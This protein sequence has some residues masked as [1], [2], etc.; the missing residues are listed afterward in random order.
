[1]F[2]ENNT[3]KIHQLT[4]FEI[5]ARLIFRSRLFYDDMSYVPWVIYVHD[6]HKRAKLASV[7]TVAC[8]L[9]THDL[10]IIS[11]IILFSFHRKCK[12]ESKISARYICERKP[13]TLIRAR[14][15][16]GKIPLKQF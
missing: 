8:T 10:G 7:S 3:G 13:F 6:W 9:F 2:D 4:T 5:K 16:R 14:L 12:F 11:K 15:V 1:M